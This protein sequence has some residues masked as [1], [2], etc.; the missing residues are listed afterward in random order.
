M[1]DETAIFKE[2]AK[3]PAKDQSETY[4]FNGSGRFWIAL[5]CAV[6][7]CVILVICALRSSP[8]E[9]SSI[10]LLVGIV[11]IYMGQNKSR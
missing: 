2:G 8:P 4:F 6:T 1:E 11:S 10:A 5:V 7:L 9:T 3:P